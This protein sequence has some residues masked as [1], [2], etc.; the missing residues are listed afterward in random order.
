MSPLSTFSV[1]EMICSY[2]RVW[3]FSVN[4]QSWTGNPHSQYVLSVLLIL[5]SIFL[6]I[7]LP[8]RSPIQVL[9]ITS[10]IFSGSIAGSGFDPAWR[11]ALLR[12]FK[13][14]MK[15]CQVRRL[16]RL[17]RRMLWTIGLPA[18]RV[19]LLARYSTAV[20]ATFAAL[21]L[22]QLLWFFCHRTSG[23][24]RFLWDE[25]GDQMSSGLYRQQRF[26]PILIG[27]IGNAQQ[28]IR[29]QN[30][31]SQAIFVAT[32]WQNHSKFLMPFDL[33]ITDRPTNV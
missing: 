12:H 31:L 15:I 16:G 20:S 33:A 21:G 5:R 27:F 18:W 11:T 17:L 10:L 6:F 29:N 4:R 19:E 25:P 14:S 8:P 24:E 1:C 23:N 2:H 30:H 22:Q 28:A 9:C 13:H 3:V 32:T 26:D 7:R